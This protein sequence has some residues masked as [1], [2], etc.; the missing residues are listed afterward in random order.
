MQE[1]ID[2][3]SRYVNDGMGA[4]WAW[5]NSL[6]TEEWFVLLGATALAGFLCMR[7]I[8]NGKRA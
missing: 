1:T 8:T 5:I 6:N 4:S 2:A 7:G 3:L